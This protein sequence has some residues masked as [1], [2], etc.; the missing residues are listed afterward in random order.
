MFKN[1][2]E[3]KHIEEKYILQK[4]RKANAETPILLL[5]YKLKF[6]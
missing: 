5:Q 4:K 6:R 1:F 2:S 3:D